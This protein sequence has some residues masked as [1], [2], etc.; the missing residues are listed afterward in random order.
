MPRRRQLSGKQ[1]CA[2]LKGQGFLQLR[3]RGSHAI[4]QKVLQDG[5]ITVPVPLHKDIKPGTLASIIRQSRL[6]PDLFA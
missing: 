6:P 3:Q 2:I 4:P 1:V 5:T